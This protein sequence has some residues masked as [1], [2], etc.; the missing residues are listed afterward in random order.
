MDMV[1]D[2]VAE[3]L[4]EELLN[5]VVEMKDRVVKFRSTLERLE[6][7]LKR[8][9]PLAKQIDDLNKRL[10]RPAEETKK[11]MD[12]MQRG[13]ELVVKCSQVQWWNCCY[14]A[15]YQ[16]ELAELEESIRGFLSLDMQALTHMYVLEILAEV[17][18]NRSNIK[19]LSG[20]CTPPQPPPF[21]VGFDVPLSYLKRE[22][23]QDHIAASVLTVTGPAGLGKTTLAQMFCWDPQVK[24][25][26]K[27]NIFFFTFG[28]TP[29]LITIVQRLFQH[30]RPQSQVPEFLSDDDA[31]NQLEQLLKQ[32][33]KGPILLV[34]D[35]VL[36]ESVSLV[37]KF[38]FQIPNYNILMTSRVKIREFDL[39]CVLKPLDEVNA[40]NLFCHSASLDQRSSHIS[41]DVVEEIVKRCSGFPLALG[42]I[43]RNLKGREAYAWQHM[44]EKLS[45]G[46]SIIYSGMDVLECLQKS[47]DGLDAKVAECFRELGLFPEAQR[48][49]AAALV[50]MWAE[51]HDETDA[52]AM[53]KIDELAYR[54][55]AD[56]VVTRNIASGT[57][58]YNYHYVTQNGLLRDLAIRQTSREPT[59]KSNRLIIYTSGINLPKWWTTQNEYHTAAHTQSISTDEAFTS[60]RCN[61]QPSEVEVLVLNLQEKKHTLSML[62]KKMNKLKVL[63]IRN[64]FYRAD[65]E[66]FELLDY[67]SDLKRIRLEKVSIPFLSK[68]G[69]PLKNMKK[70]SFFMCNVNEA[71]KNSTIQISDVLPNLE[72]M[73]IDYCDMVEL[74]FGLSDMV[75][76]KKLSITN[77]HKFSELPE[78]IGKLI[79]LESLSLYSCTELVKLPDSITSLHKLKFLDISDCLSLSKL[80]ENMG[81][82]HSLERLN[83]IGCTRLEELP[84]SI[85]EL[86]G[87]RD[88]VCDEEMAAVLWEPLKTMLSNLRIEVA[89][90]DPS[91]YW[92]GYSG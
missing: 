85:R 81:E 66:N 32:F 14:K 88:V 49:P 11:L 31:A 21:T 62:M 45:T 60:E 6:S 74:P 42:V 89:P 22:L 15:D 63:I 24:G 59:E 54:N 56:I 51:L 69:A 35:D 41:D 34:L 90:V 13:K 37:D 27:E 91:L 47:L 30:T 48:I 82:L 68:T 40:M 72:E 78:G 3:K 75:S 67:L 28:R 65:L 12:E 20:V 79:N 77:C 55:M 84:Y 5:S 39:A 38:V 71:F 23:L 53:D 86:G 57:I 80:P 61:L 1:V 70:F 50:D 25:K 73:N 92:L 83:C 7:T 10:D 26:F 43:G 52:S 29:K 4:L 46:H 8:I 18:E 33:G 64:D 44:A 76:L 87:L 17:R 16:E 36:P 58:D 9:E 19:T 2:A